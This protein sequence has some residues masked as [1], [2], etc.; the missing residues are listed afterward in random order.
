M[1][2]EA[3]VRPRDFETFFSGTYP[4]VLAQ[5]IVLCGS[6]EDAEDVTQEAFVEAYRA[7]D[8]IAG[9]ELPEAWVYRVAVQ[10]LWKT[11]RRRRTGQDR[12]PDVPVPVRAGPEQTA[13]A[14]EVL[15]LLAALP[16]RQRTTMVLF[17]LHGWSQ[18]EIARTLRMTRGGVAANVSKARQTLREALDMATDG[19]TGRDPFMAGPEPAGPGRI[20]V[21]RIGLGDDPVVTALRSTE[22]WLRAAVLA[23]PAVLD[24]ARAAVARRLEERG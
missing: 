18:K 3:A 24:R 7:W 17:C 8:R 20:E 21:S 11:H 10:R 22:A 6:R 12:L 1:N 15:R 5:V 13:E 9:Y 4:R 23:D 16:P 14:R 19:T 2:A